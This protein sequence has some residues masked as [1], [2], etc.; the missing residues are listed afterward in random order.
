MCALLCI[1]DRRVC[2]PRSKDGERVRGAVHKQGP[3]CRF[4]RYS[5][6]EQVLGEVRK[7][8]ELRAGQRHVRAVRSHRASKNQGPKT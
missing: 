5:S 4:C 1:L 7:L 8:V 3:D 2:E 6:R